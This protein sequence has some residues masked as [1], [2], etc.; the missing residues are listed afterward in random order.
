MAFFLHWHWGYEEA[1]LSSEVFR[2]KIRTGWLRWLESNFPAPAR[3][4]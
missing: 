1:R 3:D 4:P 2:L